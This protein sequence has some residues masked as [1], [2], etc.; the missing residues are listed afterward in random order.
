MTK[1]L[2]LSALLLI[3]LSVQG[4]NF[5]INTFDSFI[6]LNDSLYFVINYIWVITS[7]IWAFLLLRKLRNKNYWQFRLNWLNLGYVLVSFI[8]IHIVFL[9]SNIFI[10]MPVN[11]EGLSEAKL[12]TTGMENVFLTLYI[13]VIAP[14]CEELVHRGVVMTL[15]DNYTKGKLGWLLSSITFSLIHLPYYDM[16]LTDFIHYVAI[17]LVFGWVYKKSNSI[18]WVII[19]HI[20]WNTFVFLVSRG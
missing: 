6:R 12:Y 14:V 18:Y 13:L 5:L 19:A 20:T 16:R 15:G 11:T 2:T 1:R 4:F 8:L 10:P 7:G 17:G 9:F 3:I